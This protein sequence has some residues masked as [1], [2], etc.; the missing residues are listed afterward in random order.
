MHYLLLADRGIH[1]KV[2]THESEQ[3]C[4]AMEAAFG[5]RRYE[6]GVADV[7]ALGAVGQFAFHSRMGDAHPGA[8][9]RSAG[10]VR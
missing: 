5:Q 10:S 2:G 9:V 3:V 7:K 8:L 6:A 4:R 1:A